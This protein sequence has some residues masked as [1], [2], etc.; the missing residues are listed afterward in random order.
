MANAHITNF[1]SSLNK[2]EIKVAERY[3]KHS[4]SGSDTPDDR[5]DLKLFLLLTN[6]NNK[7]TSNTLCKGLNCTI[8]SLHALKSRLYQKITEALTS[9]KHITNTE[10]FDKLDIISLTLR[11]KLLFIRI[12]LRSLNQEK[13]ETLF[14]L[15][16]EV[17]YTATEY[18]LYDV[19]TDALIAK[20]YFK[21]IRTGVKEFEAINDT[22][23]FYDYCTKAV[24]YAADCYYRLILNNHFIKSYTKSELDKYLSLSIKQIEIDCKKTKSLQINYYLHILYFSK[25]EREK[26]YLKAI[27]Y[28][29]KLIVLIKKK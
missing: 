29:N 10:M 25:F 17:I 19:L 5:K 2:H 8:S 24:Y 1:V 14:K 7:I 27:E 21:G 6:K 20:K 3:I 23:A 18:E 12:S 4:I 26:N 9:D 28:C 22:I 11:K 16:S 13:T 15:L